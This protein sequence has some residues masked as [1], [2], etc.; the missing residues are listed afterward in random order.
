M[1]AA[2]SGNIIVRDEQVLNARFCRVL[3]KI[4]VR[5]DAL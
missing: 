4:E 1:E 2:V 5:Y 3:Q